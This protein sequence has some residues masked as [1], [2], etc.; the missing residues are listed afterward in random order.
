V[1]AEN[2]AILFHDANLVFTGLQAFLN[3]L[4][5]GGRA[6]HPHILPGSVFLIEVGAMRYCE[7]EPL[8]GQVEENC[9]AYLAGMADNNW[10]RRACHLPVYRALRKV[11]RLFPRRS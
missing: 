4:S 6:F 5:A 8:R 10:Y 3:E 1:L 9:K 11:R 7:T 2:G